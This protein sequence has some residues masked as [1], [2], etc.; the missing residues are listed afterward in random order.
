[1]L[2]YGQALLLHWCMLGV[3]CAMTL[4]ASIVLAAPSSTITIVLVVTTGILLVGR[5]LNQ[6]ALTLAE[7]G[8]TI[9]YAL[10]YV[11]PHL[12]FFDLRDLIVHGW[13]LV[14]WIVVAGAAAYALVYIV[15]FLAVAC[16]V[17]RRK[18]VN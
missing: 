1:V 16:L 2:H 14:R 6:V 15:L 8:Q 4:L 11:L 9:L 3:V 5:H 18:P 10:Y 17:F 12:E 7:P 13:G